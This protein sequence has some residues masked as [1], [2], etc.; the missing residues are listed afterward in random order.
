MTLC[1]SCGLQ[2]KHIFECSHC[3]K[4][5]CVCCAIPKKGICVDCMVLFKDDI[6]I[7]SKNDY[8]IIKEQIKNA[9]T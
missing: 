3:H 5:V 2:M 7:Q 9:D 1:N 8:N 4:T 6:Y